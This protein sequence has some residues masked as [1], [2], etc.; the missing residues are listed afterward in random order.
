MLT[1]KPFFEAGRE[2]FFK[3][4]AGKYREIVL[5]CV[6]ALY[7]RLHGPHADY[8][9]LITQKELRCIFDE[10][11]SST[12]I[13][14][15]QDDAEDDE[16]V[17][18]DARAN[19]V[20]RLLED[21]GWIEHTFD[22]LTTNRIYRLTRY[23]KSFAEVFANLDGTGLQSRQRYVRN[24]YNALRTYEESHTDPYN[25]IDALDY[26]SRVNSDLADEVA[27]LHERKTELTRQAVE[28][29]DLA[30]ESFMEY[31]QKRFVPD[32]SVKLTADSV[33]KYQSQ[34]VA[35]I[36]RIR[37][38]PEDRLATIDQGLKDYFP[39]IE[40]R[41][42][43]EPLLSILAQ[44]EL[45][46]GNACTTTMPQLREALTGFVRR[47]EIIIRQ[48]SQMGMHEN[49]SISRFLA[50]LSSL[51]ERQRNAA[52]TSLSERISPCRPRLI[53][54]G[55]LRPSKPRTAK[56]SPA[57]FE[58]SQTSREERKQAAIY[59]ALQTAFT[60]TGPEIHDAVLAQMGG[61]STICL[62]NFVVSDAVTLMVLSRAIE[63]GS[64]SNAGLMPQ[65]TVLP[66]LESGSPVRFTTRFGIFEDFLIRRV[67]Q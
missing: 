59:T 23:G 50:H 56:T 39:D 28:A 63:S 4:L 62:S 44:I 14:V 22:T 61:E 26:A 53:D 9:A 48:A 7:E 29:A 54:P 21:N 13:T 35:V 51:G 57:D 38:W 43:D 40:D 46:I 52:I 11:I 47:N 64:I 19:W 65:L 2:G 60:V 17:D 27:E 66:V 6:K 32:L 31:M 41:F 42:G 3:P 16:Y 67:D 49:G 20:R 45:Y 55:Q 5:A 15:A 18:G 24:T 12:P 25:L 58:E 36:S 30:F 33:H 37:D 8:H 34:I 1:K 10:A